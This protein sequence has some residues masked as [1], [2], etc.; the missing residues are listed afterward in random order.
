MDEKVAGRG[1]PDARVPAWTFTHYD[2]QG[3]KAV[4]VLTDEQAAAI[5]AFL[6][7]AVPAALRAPRR[8]WPL[9]DG[10]WM[11]DQGLRFWPNANAPDPAYRGAAADAA[12]RRP[13]TA[14][15]VQQEQG[16]TRVE[17]PATIP[18]VRATAKTATGDK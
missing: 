8:S 12:S 3:G 16:D 10:T 18:S 13:R 11:D 7:A 1:V 2:A 14:D 9:G 17:T 4:I 6:S 5:R 15:E